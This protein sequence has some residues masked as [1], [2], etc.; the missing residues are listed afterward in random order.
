MTTGMD[1]KLERTA[2]RVT[3]RALARTMGLSHSRIS[4]VEAYA[5]VTPEMV[6]RYRAALATCVQQR[7]SVSAA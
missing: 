4:A 5:V 1:L 6:A 3:G 2:A 7:T